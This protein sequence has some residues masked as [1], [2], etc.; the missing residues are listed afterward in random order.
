[1][2]KLNSKPFTNFLGQTK[3]MMTPLATVKLQKLNRQ[4]CFA[5]IVLESRL[6][7]KRTK[8]RGDICCFTTPRKINVEPIN[9][10]L[11]DGFDFPS[12]K[13]MVILGSMHIFRG[14]FFWLS[15]KIGRIE[16]RD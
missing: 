8:K 2:I 15:G 14:V 9:D 7:R 1:M 16:R 12:L 6:K 11:E 10:G 3:L 5:A 13:K 4:M